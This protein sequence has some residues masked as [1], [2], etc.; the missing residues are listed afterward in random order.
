MTVDGYFIQYKFI[1]PES[2]NHSSYSYQKLFRAIYGYT[3]AVYKSNGKNYRYHRKGVLS[4]YPY[5]RAGKNCVIIAPDAF[6]NL[7]AFFKTGKNP[8]H[9]WETKGNWKAVY[10]MDEKAIPE[11]KAAKALENMIARAYI[12]TGTS[13]KPVIEEM[14]RIGAGT[15]KKEYEAIVHSAA[16]KITKHPWFPKCYQQSQKLREFKKMV[17]SFK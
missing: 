9:V 3:Q 13:T 15:L 16:K 14:K 6:Q 11:Q 4:D 17:D 2:V 12:G 10:Y 8:A 7:I 5:L 1:L